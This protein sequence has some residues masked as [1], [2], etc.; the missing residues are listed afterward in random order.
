MGDRD[1]SVYLR[2]LLRTTWKAY[3]LLAVALAGACWYFY[4]AFIYQFFHGHR[5]T[6]QGTHGAMWGTI[7]ANIVQLIGV[8]HV[9]IAISATVRILQLK[10]YQQL[11][12]IAEFVTLVS[13][14]A[15]VC[16]IAGDVGRPDR[17]LYNVV[18]HG[19]FTAPFVWSATV[20]TNYLVGSCVYLYLAMRRDIYLCSRVLTRRR[21]LYR[22]L[23]LGYSD[24]PEERENLE[25]TVWWCAV[26]ILPIMVSVHSVYGWV[27][28]LQ[29][30]RPG[31]FN[32]F[33]APYFVLGAIVT[34][35]SGVVAVVAIIRRIYR[36]EQFFPNRLFK[37]L[38]VF[39]GFVTLLYLYF[40]FSE[41]LTGLYAS[42]EAE[43]G[44]FHD[45]LFGRFSWIAWTATVGGMI[46]PFWVLF[47]QGANP[48]IQSMKIVVVGAV[49][50]F[51]AMWGWRYLITVPSFFHPHIPYKL[52]E[53]SPT[54]FD[55]SLVLATYCFA[56]F[57]YTALVKLLP[58]LE[59]PEHFVPA[60]PVRPPRIRLATMR[61]LGFFKRA[62]IS[63]TLASGIGL[64][65][66][67]IHSRFDVLT[68]APAIWISGIVCLWTIPLQVCLI[69]G[70]PSRRHMLAHRARQEP[71]L[72]R[73]P[74]PLVT[75]VGLAERSSS[76]AI[77]S[78]VDRHQRAHR[79]IRR[80]ARMRVW[81]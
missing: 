79:G 9:G 54:L 36:W 39:L 35:F 2:P 47:V 20:I 63:F 57:F 4:G 42:P 34:G 33:Q 41:V 13:L 62:T 40:L 52:A 69:P 22:A 38:G 30:G 59:L 64:I 80:R 46:V 21:W 27:F 8:S 66:Y 12:R 24:T 10:R 60:R 26:I 74:R 77:E 72:L 81:A 75:A 73:P 51:F 1:I 23:A 18:M 6:G 44:V 70:F 56:I 16:N 68:P 25:R 65:A 50:I 17:F 19:N 29:P 11:A 5:V 3:A 15:A 55:W 71:A 32:P 76:P 31:W 43:R 53:Y 45:L 7:V 14:T 78:W 48:K 67:G 49:P 61:G 37:G 58:I 28:G